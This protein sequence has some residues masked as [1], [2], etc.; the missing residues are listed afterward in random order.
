M[1]N[2]KL[3]EKLL[4]VHIRIQLQIIFT[5]LTSI[6]DVHFMKLRA[7]IMLNYNTTCIILV[8][9]LVCSISLKMKGNFYSYFCIHKPRLPRC[10][11]VYQA[12][13]LSSNEVNRSVREIKLTKSAAPIRED[14]TNTD[15]VTLV[16]TFLRLDYTRLDYAR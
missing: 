10:N 2:Y 16:I 7:D 9:E 6:C 3:M 13:L 15:N 14:K 8:K 1:W 11:L 5:F 12:Q 4:D